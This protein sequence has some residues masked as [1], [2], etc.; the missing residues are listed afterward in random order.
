[1]KKPDW[2]DLSTFLEV[3]RAPTLAVAG[4][5][6]GVDVT[7]VRRRLAELEASIGMRLFEKNGRLLHLNAEGERIYSIAARMEGLSQEILSDAIDASRDLHG[8]VRISTMEGFGSYYLAGQLS[9][10]VAEHPQLS[11]Q[12]VNAPHLLNLSEREADISVNMMRPQRGRFLVEHLTQ[13]SVGLY[14]APAYLKLAGKPKKLADLSEHMF[15]T[16]VED[17]ISVPYVQWLPDVIERPNVRLRCSSLV[18]Q[19]HATCAGAGLAMLPRFMA[20]TQPQLVSVLPHEV[21]LYRDWWMVVHK[22]LE[23]VPRIRA[24]MEFLRSVC[25]LDVKLL[26]G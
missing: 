9:A 25:A 15:V 13:F 8:V 26:V 20:N 14:A 6:L 7:T 12:L 21:C 16:Y 18:A 3:A 23:M 11:V 10:L 5:R 17:L 4:S 24:V 22:D 19:F 2:S 1:M